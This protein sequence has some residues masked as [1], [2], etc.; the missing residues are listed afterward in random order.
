MERLRPPVDGG[1]HGQ[2]ELFPGGLVPAALLS[3]LG[4]R[5]N[6]QLGRV[7]V[8]PVQL[9]PRHPE[10]RQSESSLP[11]GLSVFL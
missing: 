8:T 7:H 10:M 11:L 6:A 5:S 1:R 9:V 4:P 3:S 2:L